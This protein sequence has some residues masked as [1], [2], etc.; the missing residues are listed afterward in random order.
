MRFSFCPKLIFWAFFLPL[1]LGCESPNP[2]ETAQNSPQAPN[3][4]Q[5]PKPQ[6]RTAI[7]AHLDQKKRAQSPL[8]VH[9]FVPLCDNKHQGI[10]PTSAAL[11]DGQ[12]LKT[13]LYWATSDGIRA[14]FSKHPDWKLCA[15][16]APTDTNILERLIFVRPNPSI[17]LVADAYKGNRMQ[18]TVN[19]FLASLAFQKLDTLLLSDSLQTP[20][21]AGGHADL[22]IFHGHNGLMDTIKVEEWTH[23]KAKPNDFPQKDVFINACYSSSYFNPELEKAKAFPLVR[24]ERPI[25]P[26]AAVVNEVIMEWA[27]G[28]SASEIC[29]KAKTRYCQKQPCTQGFDLFVP[30][31][32][33]ILE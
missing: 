16:L 21:L 12:N 4:L 29:R 26:S 31:W 20:L 22:F 7:L 17:Y 6:D 1:F 3:I 19:D 27:K 14:Y 23:T 9:V 32:D 10:A 5:A 30:N 25:F 24:T 28:V 13:N 11:G 2:P 8:V 15:Q 18:A 33:G